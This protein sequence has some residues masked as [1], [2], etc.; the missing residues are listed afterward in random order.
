MKLTAY[1]VSTH[2]LTIRPASKGREW[3]H[4]SM[5]RCLP[6]T[7]ANAHGWELVCESGFNLL[8]DGGYAP[9]SLSIAFDDPSHPFNRHVASHFGMGI[10]T[11][12]HDYLFVTEDGWN[13]MVTGPSNAPKHGI[14]PLEGVVESD[15]AASPFTMNWQITRP[16]E[17]VR[18]DIGD[19]L[20]RFYP[21]PHAY[22]EEIEPSIESIDAN[23]DLKQRFAEWNESRRNFN[24]KLKDG[25]PE[26]KAQ[27]WQKH[28]M[29]GRDADGAKQAR[30][31]KTKLR[32]AQFTS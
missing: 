24:Q 9:D 15:W 7:I 11:F 12:T 30:V 26:T 23:P 25:D 28:Y 20:C 19:A 16:H 2:P 3:M 29:H 1:T 10:I 4:Q 17:I 32:L 13:M 5:S 8:W 22:L 6:L 14:S 18:F 31:H 21:V 27:G